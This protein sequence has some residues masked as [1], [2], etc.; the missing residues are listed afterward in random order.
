MSLI[1][2]MQKDSQRIMN[3]KFGFASD[4]VLTDPADV[5]HSLKAIVTVIYNLVDP[6]T[7]VPVSGYLATAISECMTYDNQRSD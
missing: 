7:G 6:D 4:I 2:R 5:S 1:E 3:S